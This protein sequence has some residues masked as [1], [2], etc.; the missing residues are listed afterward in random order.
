VTIGL[1]AAAMGSAQTTFGA[2]LGGGPPPPPSA[3]DRGWSLSVTPYAWLPFFQGDVTVKGRSVEVDVNPFELLEHLDA[4]P[5][6]AYTEARKG[7][8]VLYNDIFYAKVDVDATARRSVRNLTVGA[9]ADADIELAI[10]EAG[11]AFE[12]ARWSSGYTG[13]L[14]GAAAFEPYTAVDVL[15]GARYWRQDV[16][17][18]FGLT[19]A[20]DVSGLVVTRNRAIARGGDVDWVDPLVGFR[21]RQGV[22]PGQELV[23]RADVGGFDAGSKFSWNVLGAYSFILAVRNGVTYSGMLG[24]RALSVDFEKGSGN[25]KYEYDVVQ[26]GPVV[27]LT[28][29]F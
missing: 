2:D 15:A 29:G 22:A 10:I 27:G 4:V 23:L 1:A 20:L 7:P 6:M 8:L 17:L 16:D 3:P 5:F 11:G 19:A 28:I 26:H 25:N 24:Y 9:S 18:R 21:I 12:I 13:G 14:R